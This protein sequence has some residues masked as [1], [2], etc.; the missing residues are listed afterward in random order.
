MDTNPS[1]FTTTVLAKSNSE[2]GYRTRAAAE[3]KA[4]V[5]KAWFD[6]VGLECQVIVVKERVHAHDEYIVTLVHHTN[7]NCRG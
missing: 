2:I 5:E 3:R 1:G 4:E 6:K 7:C